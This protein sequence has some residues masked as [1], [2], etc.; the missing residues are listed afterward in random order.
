MDAGSGEGRADGLRGEDERVR[1]SLGV[2]ELDAQAAAA[3]QDPPNPNLSLRRFVADGVFDAE[4]LGDSGTQRPRLE[5]RVMVEC[6][7]DVCVL[8]LRFV[9]ERVLVVGL[10]VFRLLVVGVVVERVVDLR[11]LELCLLDELGLGARPVRAHR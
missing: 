2:G 10:V 1:H 8:E 4:R 6:V 9:V 5:R 3:V 11:I 7:L